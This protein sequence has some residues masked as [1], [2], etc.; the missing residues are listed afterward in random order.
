MRN[1][2]GKL[3][4][5]ESENFKTVRCCSRVTFVADRANLAETC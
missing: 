1:E 2:R 5:A 3:L 4:F